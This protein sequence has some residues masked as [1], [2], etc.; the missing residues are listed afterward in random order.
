[1]K[2]AMKFR[3]IKLL[4]L[5]C[6]MG[7][8]QWGR[9]QEE[10]E[11]PKSRGFVNDY[12]GVLDA[13]STGIIESKLKA[14]SDST[15]TQIAVVIEKTMGNKDAFTRAMEFARGWKVGSKEN[16]NGIV[17]YLAIED[18]KYHTVVAQAAQGRLPD[19]LVGQI[20]RERLVPHLKGGDYALAVNETVTAYMQA[21]QGEFVPG[22]KTDNV[23]GWVF[24][25][26]L[27]G[28]II[29]VLVIN[30]TKAGRG[31]KG[32]GAY[33]FPMGGWGSG[34]GSGWG[35]GGGGGGWGGFG[36]GGGFDGGGAGGS[37]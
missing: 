29:F 1:M 27:F 3:G 10:P 19:G 4:F 14:Y 8:T 36:G 26:V 28:L 31:F 33:W 35:G 23:P 21:L 30:N 34:G 11:L 20:E 18:R 16:N 37:W 7:V 13:S 22:K 15:S 5:A 6:L 12:A 9:A 24:F 25:V 17:L 32:G 2:S